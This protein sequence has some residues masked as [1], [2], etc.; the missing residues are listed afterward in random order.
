MKFF[1]IRRGA[2]L[3]ELIVTVTILSVVATGLVRLM[4][5]QSRFLNEHEG[6]ANARRVARSP[7]TLMIA[8]IR[9]A[10]A[11]SGLI[12]AAADSFALRV[13]YRIG[14]SCGNG[15]AVTTVSFPPID[16]LIAGDASMLGYGWLDLNGPHYVNGGNMSGGSGTICKGVGVDTFPAMNLVKTIT[17]MLG[18]AVIGS[19][20]FVYQRV[21]YSLRNSVTVPGSLGLFRQIGNN[22]IEELVAPLAQGSQFR[23]FPG[24]G[25]APTP[26]PVIGTTVL[27]IDLRLVGLNERNVTNGKT[28]AVPVQTAI[29]FQNR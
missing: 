27:G 11:D 6:Q 8:D 28:Q 15:G 16:S 17:P 10:D 9:M 24:V 4:S 1:K 23:Y 7:L 18:S 25:G 12:G 20:I 22:G 3:V 21:I 26:N 13:P 14:V 19:P 2:T 29:Y 5:S